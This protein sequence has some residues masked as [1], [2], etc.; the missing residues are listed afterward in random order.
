MPPHAKDRLIS[1]LPDIAI[2][3]MV[4]VISISLALI[5]RVDIAAWI[6]LPLFIFLGL[7]WFK[8]IRSAKT[9]TAPRD[10][11]P[12]LPEEESTSPP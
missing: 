8:E 7:A 2:L 11:I 4:V 9:R 5:Q 6:L 10:L 1:H 3:T 12:S